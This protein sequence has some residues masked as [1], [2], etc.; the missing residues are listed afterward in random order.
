MNSLTKKIMIYS[1]ACTLQVG[2]GA[3]LVEAASI[4]SDAPQQIVQL[5]H[6]GRESRQGEHDRRQHAEYARHEREMRRR[7]RES[8][9]DWYARRDR[10]V[11]RHNRAMNDL[12][13]FL[14]GVG[15]GAIL[16]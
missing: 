10:E 11:Y 13:I 3:T 9:R 1:L 15:I 5:D 7:D 12:E 6:R 8:E 4:R 16:R 14:V 2:L